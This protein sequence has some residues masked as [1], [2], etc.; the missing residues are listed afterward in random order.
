MGVFRDLPY[1]NGPDSDPVRHRLDLFRPGA[2]KD[3]PVVVLVHGG[4]W[5]TGDKNFFGHGT[6]L[7]EGLARQGV[8]VVLPSYRLAPAVGNADQARDVAAAIAWTVRNVR[9][10]GGRPDRLFLCG[11]S[12]GGQLVALVTA[13]PAF[14]RAHDLAASAIQGVV[15]V[16][17]VYRSPE[18][19]LQLPGVGGAGLALRLD[20]F[21]ALFGAAIEAASPLRF[22]RPGLPPFLLIN[23]QRDL[24]TL[25]E[26][27]R[28]FAAALEAAHCGV[29]LLEVP[30]RDHE[31]V[32]F[33]ATTADDP[34]ARAIVG[35]VFAKKD[36]AKVGGAKGPERGASAP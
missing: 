36:P 17:G 26:G 3:Y 14:L 33:R 15:G 9:Q 35:M 16:S 20:P 6:A 5:V 31:S 30:N 13:D 27:A 12:A 4:A 1:R 24:P 10:F 8:G 7:G 21:Q 28:A 23:A 11:H 34:V 19:R 29:R 2:V 32:M 25:A 18:V 22:V